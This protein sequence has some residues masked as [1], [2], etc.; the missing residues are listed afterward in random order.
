MSTTSQQGAFRS[1]QAG[2][3]LDPNDNNPRPH[4]EARASYPAGRTSASLLE[5][6]PSLVALDAT[7]S[8]NDHRGPSG[9]DDDLTLPKAT[10][11]KLIAGASLPR[12]F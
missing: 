4:F 9:G 3:A 7:M 11:Q 8:D 1:A 10:V 6:L 12:P 2:S 5:H